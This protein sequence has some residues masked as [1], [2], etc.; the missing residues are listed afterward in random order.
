M[1]YKIVRAILDFFFFIVFR[2][3]VEGRENVPEKAPSL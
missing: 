2:L 1:G 3:H